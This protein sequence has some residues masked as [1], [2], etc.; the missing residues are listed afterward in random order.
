MKFLTNQT[1]KI[2]TLLLLISTTSLA[3]NPIL[4][5]EAREIKTQINSSQV[6]LAQNNQT[7]N[8]FTKVG[9][10]Q[11]TSG[12]AQIVTENGKKYL[13]LSSD[14]TTPRGPDLFLILHRQNKIKKSIQEKNYISLAP[15]KSLSGEQRYLIPNSINLNDYKSIGIWCRQFNVTFAYAPLSL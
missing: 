6:I 10:P 4:P 1:R 2:S 12:T 13:V 14:F 5:S 15:L 9:K 8:R 7:K 11:N 3:L